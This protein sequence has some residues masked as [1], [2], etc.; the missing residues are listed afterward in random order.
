M[1]SVDGIV[2]KPGYGIATEAVH[3]QLPF[4]FT[5]RGDFPDEPDIVDWLKSYGRSEEIDQKQWL[6]GNFG[7]NLIELI[8]QSPK[9]KIK[10]NGAEVAAKIIVEKYLLN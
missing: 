4:L 10:C 2:S 3:Y 7:D 9:A 8:Q 6:S 1:A 5:C